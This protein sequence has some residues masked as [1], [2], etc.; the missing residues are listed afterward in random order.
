[1][2]VSCEKASGDKTRKNKKHRAKIR[3]KTCF[4]ETEEVM[5]DLSPNFITR[6]Q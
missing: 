6:A 4:N 5:Q 2:R 1:M 3:F